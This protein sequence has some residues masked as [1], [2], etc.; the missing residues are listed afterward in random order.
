MQVL[1]Y[2]N[3]ILDNI[4]VHREVK[5]YY[6]RLI[7]ILSKQILAPAFLDKLDAIIIPEDFIS[8]VME[9]QKEH[10]IGTPSVTDNVFGRAYGKMMYDS[11]AGKYSVF[12]DSSLASMIMEDQVFDVFFSQ[13]D[14]QAYMT[15][16][17]TRGMGINI[18]AHELSHIEFALRVK[19]PEPERTLH[20]G[21]IQH[22]FV[23]LDEYFACRKAT[24]F[25][26]YS[27]ADNDEKFILDL[28]RQTE[29]DRWKYK[30]AEITLNDFCSLFHTYT[31]MALIRLASVIGANHS[32]NSDQLPFSST[33]V[34]RYAHVLSEEFDRLYECVL[35]GL[36]V[37]IPTTVTNAIYSYFVDM[38]VRIEETAQGLYYHIPD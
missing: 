20:S 9:F 17:R 36:D 15:A 25:A 24:G 14:E 16:K 1:F 28:E 3:H 22:G 11:T 19:R 26:K 7:T 10:E 29:D 38:G 34:G 5:E 18:L 21:L 33:K 23:L 37:S 13:T 31:E 2:A 35:S 27:L 6:E 12:I 8:A 4:E 32:M 30:T